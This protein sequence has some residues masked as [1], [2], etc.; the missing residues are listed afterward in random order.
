[1]RC[2]H[3]N[4]LSDLNPDPK[5][6]WIIRSGFYLRKSDSRKI[7][8]YRCKV[9]QKRFS[10]ATGTPACFQKKRRITKP[11]ALLLNSGVSQRRAAL[12]LRVNPKTVVR[13]FRYIA[14]Q[15]RRKQKAWRKSHF[16]EN[17]LLE[18]QFDDLETIEHTKCKPVSV[19]LAVDPKT[20]KI[21]SFQVSRMPAKGHLAEISRRKY[22]YRPDERGEAWDQMMREL[23]PVVHPKATWSS[24][25]NPHYPRY[26]FRH[27]PHARHKTTKGGRASSFGLGE[28]KKLRFDPIFTLNHTCAMLRANLNRLF[29][30]TWCV[31]KTLQGLIDH[32]SIYMSYHNHVLTC[33]KLKVSSPRLGGS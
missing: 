1:M 27:F 24:D 7:P 22:G 12:I 9:C 16:A 15:E 20:R 2:P 8:R 25:E 5:R 18:V 4:C 6:R 17:K 19:C 21:L 3:P 31:S 30:R 33:L 23:L 28:L 26:L 29:R 32:I 14:S 13:R 11:L 10:S